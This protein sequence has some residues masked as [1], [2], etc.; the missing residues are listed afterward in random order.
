[1]LIVRSGMSY[2]NLRALFSNETGA[3]RLSEDFDS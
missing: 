1:V 2:H 3:N